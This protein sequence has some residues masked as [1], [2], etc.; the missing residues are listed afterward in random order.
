MC[1][2][3]CEL[4]VLWQWTLTVPR[5]KIQTVEGLCQPGAYTGGTALRAVFIKRECLISTRS[6]SGVPQMRPEAG[7][8]LRR[9]ADRRL[10]VI[11]LD[12]RPKG[13]MPQA[14]LAAEENSLQGLLAELREQGGHVDAL[15]SCSHRPED[16]CGCWGS[17]P[18][19]LYAAAGQLDL[20]LD[21]CYLLCDS[22]SDVVLAYRVGCRPMLLLNGHSITDLYDG[23]QP[24][25]RDFP[26][27]RD[28]SAAVEYVLCEDDANERWGHARQPSSPTQLTEEPL[29]AVEAPELSPEL[30][31]LAPL[32]MG[33]GTLLSGI[34]PLGRQ[35]RQWLLLFVLGGVWL[36]LGIAYLLTH[37]YRVQPFPEF[38][39]YLTLQ[40]IPRPLRGLLFMLTGV[41]VVV[42]SLR[43]F[44][45]MFPMS[46]RRRG[47]PS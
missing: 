10:F 13:G 45:H 27:A 24:E 3:D 34:P 32:A 28:L 38:V 29:P 47:R 31:L 4:R 20:R 19:F 9:L 18:G 16:S 12:C 23:H 6:E 26:I 35:A 46:G 36:S 15:M 21:E 1:Y 5:A 33:K 30:R 25:P 8:G 37:L 41:V 42:L 44:L 2:T 14:A 11:L 7:D 43:A 39:W 40:F 17:F 22:A